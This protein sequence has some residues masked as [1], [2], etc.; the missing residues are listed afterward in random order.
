MYFLAKERPR[1]H[2]PSGSECQW[3]AKSVMTKWF[4]CHPIGPNSRLLIPSNMIILMCL[5]TDFSQLN[6]LCSCEE[7]KRDCLLH[8]S[9]WSSELSLVMFVLISYKLN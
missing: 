6:L 3:Q 9:S 4:L 2:L 1:H 8:P 5:H 7:V